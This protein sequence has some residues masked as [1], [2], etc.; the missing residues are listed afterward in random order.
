MNKKLHALKYVA[1]DAIAAVVT[2][3]LFFIYRK[4]YVEPAKFGYDISIS[5]DQNF[6][7]ALAVIPLFW[8]WLYFITGT[9][10]NIYRK[11]R[12]K[13]F[14]QTFL[15]SIIGTLILFFV[16]ILDDEIASYK[17]YYKSYFTLFTYHFSIT[18]I[19]RLILTTYTGIRI[20]NRKIGFYTLIIGAN[21]NAV[22]LYKEITNQKH[23]SGNRLVGFTHVN[24]ESEKFMLSDFLP[25]LGNCVNL[26]TTIETNQIEEVII[27]VESSEHKS[28]GNII[29]V[30]EGLPV[31]IKI[32]PDMYDIL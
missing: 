13:E 8:L 10:K 21:Q 3:A 19:F 27:A 25:H 12:L 24:D 6:Y 7:Y 14:G 28:L 17:Q 23:S 11:S 5:F 31:I 4:S 16:V 26:R 20:K 15:I 9:Y 1:L 29:T 22:D 18:V 32:I 2:W 30:L